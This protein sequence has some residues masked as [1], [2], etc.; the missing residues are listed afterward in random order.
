MITLESGYC[1]HCGDELDD[2]FEDITIRDGKL[3]HDICLPENLI[4][5]RTNER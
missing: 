5:A 4:D 1:E 3:Y 2:R